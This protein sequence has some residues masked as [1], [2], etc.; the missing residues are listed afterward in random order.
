MKIV[1]RLGT[2]NIRSTRNEEENLIHTIERY[3]L[4]ILDLSETKRKEIIGH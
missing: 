4:D 2:W 3:N 1:Y